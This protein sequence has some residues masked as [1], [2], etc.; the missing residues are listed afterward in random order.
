MQ[1][2][3]ISHMNSMG[4][5]PGNKPNEGYNHTQ[6]FLHP[7][8]HFNLSTQ[9][10]QTTQS[11]YNAEVDLR[12]GP[13]WAAPP[14][15]KPDDSLSLSTINTFG[16]IGNLGNFG[17][18]GNPGSYGNYGALTNAPNVSNYGHLGNIS[19]KKETSGLL[20]NLTQAMTL[21]PNSNAGQ[22]SWH[23]AQVPK[24]TPVRK[25]ATA[26]LTFGFLITWASCELAGQF[27][28]AS[29]LVNSVFQC[30]RINGRS[31]QSPW[32]RC[33]YAAESAEKSAISAGSAA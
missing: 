19:V 24:N 7:E 10:K 29:S 26:F 30:W 21:A 33:K 23:P 25:F 17:T 1:S 4:Q 2:N 28:K 16:N 31:R 20:Q 14:P 32:P 5:D 15:Q 3:G 8:R 13:S 22:A 12:L 27:S 6:N 18:L 11:N 9:Q